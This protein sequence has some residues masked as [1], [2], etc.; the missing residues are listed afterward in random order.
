MELSRTILKELSKVTKEVKDTNRNVYARGT[1]K[2]VGEDKFVQIDGSESLTPISEVVDI[3]DG[4]RVLVSIENHNATIMGNFT[5]PPSARKEQE[6]IDKAENAQNV[7]DDANDAAISADNK[8]Q[9]AA[10]KADE[11]VEIASGVEGLANEA[12]QS[13]TEAVIAANDAAQKADEAKKEANAVHD[14]AQNAVSEAGKAQESAATAQREVERINGEV[15]AVKGDISVAFEELKNQAD[16]TDAIKESLEITYAKK[17]DVSEVEANLKTEISKKVG[18]L[19]T[20]VEENYAGKNEVVDLEVRLQSQITQNSEGLTSTTSK[21]EKLESDTEIAQQ[22]VAEALEKAEIAGATADS[23]KVKADEAQKAA[24]AAKQNAETA[25]EKAQKAQKAAEEA[26]SVANAADEAITEA[27]TDLNEAKQNLENVQNRVGATEEEIA[28][29]QSKVDAAQKAVDQALADS[30]EANAAANKAQDAANKAQAD[31]TQAQTDATNAQNKADN[32]QLAAGEAQKAADQALKDV[33]ALTKRVTTAETAIKQNSEAIELSAT[34]VDKIGNSIS[35]LTEGNLIVNGFGTIKNNTN[36]TSWTFDGSDKCDSYPSFKYESD[37]KAKEVRIS[38]NGIPIDISKVYKFDIWMKSIGEQK[39]Y[40][41]FTEH[42]ID[43]LPIT[44]ITKTGVK[45]STTTLAKDLKNGDTVVYLTSAAGWDVTSSTHPNRLGLIF[46]NYKDSTGYQYPIGVYSRNYYLNIYRYDNVDK[47]NNTITLNRP[48]D[49]GTFQ[50]GTSVSQTLDGG[51]Y[52]YFGYI[53]NT[54][55]KEWTKTTHTIKGVDIP[56]S[57][58]NNT[59]SFNPATKY[60]NFTV[61]HNYSGTS[62]TA[63]TTCISGVSLI[64][65]TEKEN[66]KNNYYNKTETDAKI[67]VVSDSI[68]ST[69]KKEVV[70][71]IDKVQ[72]GVKNLVL[73][74]KDKRTS[75]DYRIAYYTLSEN[76][77]EGETYT[78]SF[79]GTTK[80]GS[81]LLSRDLG[82]SSIIKEVPYNEDKG[83]YSYTFECPAKH[84]DDTS[85]NNISF[86]NYPYA[87][88]H[89]C[90]I[91]SVKLEKGSKAT[92]W[93]PAPED[94]AT[95]EEV[96]NAQ[97]SADKAQQAADSAN[98]RV[99]ISESTIKQLSDSIS[100]IVTDEK[101][102]SMMQQT[103]TGWTFNMGA[104]NQTLNSA[105]DQLNN[106]SGQVTEAEKIIDGVNDLANDIAKKTAYMNVTT[107]GGQPAIELGQTNSGFKLRITNTSIDFLDGSSRIAYISNKVLYIEKAIIKD[108]LQI[109]DGK[110]FVWK[111]RSNGNMGLR[112]VGG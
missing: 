89:D 22:H 69:V 27:K 68:T 7:A 63:V 76:W 81:F 18:E 96:E 66:L 111:R 20:T 70:E 94:M 99:T 78:I 67:K 62:T 9:S 52:K 5:F 39:I 43:G 97:M 19:Q 21:V 112:W 36:F 38:D 55:P 72:I 56:Y 11:A 53:N 34:K 104:I 28:E 75:T 26:K 50:A 58:N 30:A 64:D 24:D 32:A 85:E 65:A 44:V 80:E 29:A 48:W 6:A 60:I 33:T 100:M 17:T 35:S 103:S 1:V 73:D 13:A 79:K 74:S 110:G 51:G 45:A 86:W 25:D 95:G 3:E 57:G 93:T 46:W 108:E 10:K 23:A 82:S 40:I 109:G 90:T 2:T 31:A 106:L 91:E 47:A 42:D 15:T 14:L 107:V 88:S 16:E 4:D 102:N 8:A 77:I 71:E 12:K 37:V 84:A 83:M 87:A 61:L 105:K 59:G 92:D 98:S 101:G 49:K 41:G 54:L